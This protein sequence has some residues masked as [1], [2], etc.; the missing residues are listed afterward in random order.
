MERCLE[1]PQRLA[2]TPRLQFHDSKIVV[3][4][5]MCRVLGEDVAIE[6]FGFNRISSP[7][8][9]DGSL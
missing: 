2:G 9:A 8:L 3:C 6:A 1:M 7:M 4:E 5:G